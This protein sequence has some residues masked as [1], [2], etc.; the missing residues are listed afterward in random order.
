MWRKAAVTGVVVMDGGRRYEKTQRQRKIHRTGVVPS[1][2]V[3][4]HGIAAR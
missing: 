2:P 1:M 4:G 3:P